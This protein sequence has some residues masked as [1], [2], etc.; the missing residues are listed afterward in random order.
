M[1]ISLSKLLN[2]DT[3]DNVKIVY[4]GR[5]QPFSTHHLEVYQNFANRFGKDKVYIVTTDKTELPDSPL[6]FTQK[7]EIM[8]MLGVPF[9]KIIQV[10]NTYAPVIKNNLTPGW[11]KILSH[12]DKLL[13]VLG[14]KDADR[15]KPGYYQEFTM[16]N[17]MSDYTTH[18]YTIT[19]KADIKFKDPTSGKTTELNGTAIRNIFT[20][21]ETDKNQ[22]Y[23]Q[24]KAAYKVS[25][26]KLFWYMYKILTKNMVEESVIDEGIKHIEDLKPNELLDLLDS[27]NV[28]DTKFEVTE[29]VDGQSFGFG[30]NNEGFYAKSKTKKFTNVNQYPSLYFYDDFKKYHTLLSDIDFIDIVR[31]V[32]NRDIQEVEF[33]GEAV[34]SYD[35]NIILYDKGI[36]GDGVYIVFG[37][38][39]DG[40]S[41]SNSDISKVTQEINKQSD[42]T[43]YPNFVVV[44]QGVKFEEKYITTLRTIIEKYGNILSK[45]V[46][47]PIDKALK[48]KVKKIINLIG[49][50]SKDEFLGKM[51]NYKSPL[52][53][54]IEGFVVKLPDGNLVKIVDKNKFTAGKTLNWKYMDAMGKA[55]RQFTSELKKNPE[56]LK[57]GLKKVIK[58]TQSLYDDFK[59]GH[60]QFTIPKKK[61]DTIESFK[62]Q[63]DRLSK[64]KSL[65]GVIDDTALIDKILTKNLGESLIMSEGGKTFPDMKAIKNEYVIPTTNFCLENLRMSELKFALTGNYKKPLLGDIDLGVDATQLAQIIGSK[66]DVPEDKDGFF[67]DL[68]SYIE[69]NKTDKIIDYKINKGLQQFSVAVPAVDDN[70][71]FIP[72]TNVQLDVMIGDREWMRSALGP[73]DNSKYKAAH[74]NFLYTAAF[75][76]IEMETGEVDIK[77]KYQ[78]NMKQGVE[79][80]DFTFDG[81]GK[82]VKIGKNLITGNV[83]DM[84]HILFDESVSYSQVNSFEELYKMMLTDK[85]RYPELRDGIFTEFVKTVKNMKLPVP[86]EMKKYE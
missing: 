75:S 47:N 11:E 33:S 4:P 8:K 18:G 6:N 32:L 60:H 24:F 52:G 23:Q 61:Q 17:K 28:D 65:L 34:P 36:I 45:S 82:R 43:F 62:I 66:F 68:K 30:M 71:Q 77:R 39:A 72:D 20:N 51:S 38:T 86:N 41:L 46:R 59:T 21:T 63:F 55:Y 50:K 22:K 31:G 76:Q 7:K 84:V 10:K 48:E 69:A 67:A 73:A 78:F 49:K 54:D 12:G 85:F 80:V 83:E 64:I 79:T 53:G 5:F 74:R 57:L 9:E 35:S 25:D 70:G 19:Y 14:Q 42:I 58:D 13:V 56:S 44:S 26:K 81:K 3:T 2:E 27:W 29:K 15:L 40:E 16:F 37:I 1:L